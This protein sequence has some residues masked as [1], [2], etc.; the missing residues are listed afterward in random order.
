P[1]TPADLVAVAG[2]STQIDLGWTASTDDVGVA[3]YDVFRNGV[4]IASTAAPAY[5][6]TGLAP[7]TSY[8]YSVSAFD[9]AGNDPARSTPA[10][11]TTDPAP[12]DTS[13]PTP[14][15]NLT[16]TAV[17][18]SQ[19]NLSWTASTDNVGVVAYDVFRNGALV[20]SP[21][22]PSF[23]DTGLNASTLYTYAVSAR[24]AAGNASPLSPAATATTNP[25]GSPGVF[26][27]EI[28]VSGLNLPTALKF[29]PGGDLLAL[30]LVGTIRRIHFG[31]WQ[32]E[33]IPFL[34]LTNIGTLNGQQG[35]MDLVFD[36]GFA[37]NH[38][39][40]VFYT[41]GSPNRDRV[42]RFTANADLTGTVAG[43]ELV[44]YQD[45]N[46]ANAEHHGGALNFGN[47]G[48]LYVTTGDHFNADD[49]QSLQSPRGK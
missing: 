11:A 45:P 28:L 18:S 25:S 2:S 26:Q 29:I 16:A 47:D 39:Y 32:V 23:Q 27:N 36:P 7:A 35:L 10:P 24:D 14:P 20:A 33:P 17:S 43:S 48:K 44:I 12:G 5:S 38:F 9:A 6:D 21:A 49:S 42:S 41:L 37:T 15:E 8:S 4:R 46:D 3:G 34:A 1:S 31:T 13:P 22:G 30:E 40:Y 19:I